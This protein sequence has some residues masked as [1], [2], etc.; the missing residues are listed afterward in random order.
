[1]LTTLQE[2]RRV[3]E[4]ELQARAQARFLD[5]DRLARVEVS[6][7]G[8]EEQ[9]DALARMMSS[10]DAPEPLLDEAEDLFD[11]F[12]QIEERAEAIVEAGQG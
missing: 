6:A 4:D 3:I 11:Y 2:A 7:R 10:R 8:Y 9:A 12:R 1:M 5:R